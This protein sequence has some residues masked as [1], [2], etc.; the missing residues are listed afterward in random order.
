M[1]DIGADRIAQE[2]M[3]HEIT[4]RMA[5]LDDCEAMYKWR[6]AEETG[7]VRIFNPKQI[8]FDEHCR[9]LIESL[10]NPNHKY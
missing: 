4:L 1:D 3:P 7:D 2:I 10:K 8:S 6:N 5:T 9:W